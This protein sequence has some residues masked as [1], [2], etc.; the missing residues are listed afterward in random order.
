MRRQGQSRGAQVY[1][2][3]LSDEKGIYPFPD[4]F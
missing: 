1:A 3:H 4:L 2:M